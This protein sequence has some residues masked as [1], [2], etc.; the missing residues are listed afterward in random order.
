MKKLWDIAIV[1]IIMLPLGNQYYPFLDVFVNNYGVSI[2]D[3]FFT[4]LIL[5]EIIRGISRNLRLKVRNVG[6]YSLVSLAILSFA[7]VL[8]TSYTK[9]GLRA[10]RDGFNFFMCVEFI[11]YGLIASNNKLKLERFINLVEIGYIGYTMVSIF[12]YIFFFG[13]GDRVSGN[14]FSLSIIIVPYEIYKYLKRIDYKKKHFIYIILSF[15]VNAIISQDRTVIGLTVIA[16][17][18]EV[19]ILFKKRITK[20]MVMG[21]MSIMSLG[22]IGVGFLFATKAS[23]IVRILTG[24]DIDTLAGRMFTFSYYLEQI[25]L[26][27][28]GYGFGYVMHFFTAG[29]Y[30]LPGETYQVDNAFIVYGVKGGVLFAIIYTVLAL[31]PVRALLNNPDEKSKIFQYSYFL[32]LISAYAMTSQII[33]GRGT[34][35]FIWTVVAVIRNYKGKTYQGCESVVTYENK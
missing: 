17:A 29:N 9:V 8:Y 13:L 4:L 27:P 15:F 25:R 7:F 35:L 22:I 6:F 32:L 26:N 24:G 18:I 12:S 14:T 30:M 2:L 5:I 1:L 21:L 19:L 20:K 23:V 10:V 28:F 31:L 33:Q 11:I 34:A 16:V 3:V